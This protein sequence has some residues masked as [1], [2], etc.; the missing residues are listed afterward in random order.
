[1]EPTREQLQEEIL[2]ILYQKS[3]NRPTWI[4]CSEIYWN[5]KNLKVSERSVKEILDWLVKNDLVLHQA[6]KYQIDKREFL[7][8]AK[9]KTIE[10]QM[11]DDASHAWGEEAVVY[12]SMVS[13]S[14]PIREI[15]NRH[16]SPSHSVPFIGILLSFVLSG[17][18]LG[19]LVFNIVSD[20][21]DKEINNKLES[22]AKMTDSIPE[23][24]LTVPSIP[25][26][27]DYHTINRNIKN[28]NGAII[29]QQ[30]INKTL[31]AAINGE[32]VYAESI[33][34]VIVSQ[35]GE[36]KRL[37]RDRNVYLWIIGIGMF[38]LNGTLIFRFRKRD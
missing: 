35:Q 22:L 15:S 5:I 6:D 20:S 17:I 19:L 9:R 10:N 18:V 8:M 21:Q 32:R 23:T 3:I 31:E 26:A 11:T 13:D 1:M 34:D 28:L 37:T 29:E 24:T 12:N 16:L 14:N 36:I 33:R 7:D 27:R 2:E 30:S 38:L 4:T 25:Y